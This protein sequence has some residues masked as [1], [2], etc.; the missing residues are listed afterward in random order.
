MNAL[1][2]ALL[3][4]VFLVVLVGFAALGVLASIVVGGW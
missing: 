4:L 3:V 2:W 1:R